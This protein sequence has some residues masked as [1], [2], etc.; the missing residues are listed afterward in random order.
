MAVGGGLLSGRK[1]FSMPMSS[2]SLTTAKNIL[3]EGHTLNFAQRCPLYFKSS[4]LTL[5]IIRSIWLW[6]KWRN[7]TQC[8]PE[9]FR[10]LKH[11]QTEK[12]SLVSKKQPFW[13]KLNNLFFVDSWSS[14]VPILWCQSWFVSE[15]YWH[16]CAGGTIF[17]R[18]VD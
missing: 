8:L 1:I 9:S 17:K 5:L 14:S 12:G 7:D 10:S 13:I 2:H 18:L 16:C 4:F 15:I 3:S 6:S 11:I